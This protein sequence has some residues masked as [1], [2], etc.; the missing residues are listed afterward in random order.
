MPL[1]RGVGIGEGMCESYRQ[2]VNCNGVDAGTPEQL[3]CAIAERQRLRRKDRG[4]ALLRNRRTPTAVMQGP[5]RSSAKH[6]S[7]V[8]SG[9]SGG[10]VRARRRW[11]LFKE[12]RDTARMHAGHSPLWSARFQEHSD[13]AHRCSRRAPLLTSRTAAHVA[14]RGL[15][16]GFARAVL[17]APQAPCVTA[18]ALFRWKSK[19]RTL[20]ML[21]RCSGSHSP[22]RAAAATVCRCTRTVSVMS[23]P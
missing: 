22:N 13:A 8:R 2:L 1:S 16:R 11:R 14:H 4:A 6:P 9:T 23:R 19:G 20:S 17:H 7:T 3:C 5:R 18:A 12:Q 21:S 15:V 10:N